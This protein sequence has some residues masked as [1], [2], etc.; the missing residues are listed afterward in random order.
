MS[1]RI[2]FLCLFVL[3]NGGEVAHNSEIMKDKADF[4]FDFC[5]FLCKRLNITKRSA[6]VSAWVRAHESADGWE[7]QPGHSQ[8]LR[9]RDCLHPG[10][11]FGA[12]PTQME[13]PKSCK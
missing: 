2:G 9:Q 8:R 5:D 1:W 3:L 6:G 11:P 4:D 12:M 13:Q 10:N 7:P